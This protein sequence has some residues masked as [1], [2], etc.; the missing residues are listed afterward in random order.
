MSRSTKLAVVRLPRRKPAG[1]I[2]AVRR[3]F[4]AWIDAEQGHAFSAARP[5]HVSSRVRD[6]LVLRVVS[7]HQPGR[8]QP[9]T[10][11]RGSR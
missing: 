5:F 10:H 4:P 3:G 1:G 8:L 2:A 9:S 6:G 7:T 11:V